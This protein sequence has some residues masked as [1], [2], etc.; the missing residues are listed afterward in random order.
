MSVKN[1]Y[2]FT[3]KKRKEFL[4]MIAG[5]M[6]RGV[7]AKALGISRW[8]VTNHMKED[9]AFAEA[10]GE[11]EKDADEL[12]EDALYAAACSGNVVAIQVWLYNRQPDVW[13]DK[14]KVNTEIT[15]KDG[16]ELVIK[17]IEV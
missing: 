11:A 13:A 3:A 14:R 8:T 10:V 6:R 16:G 7:A 2:K 17:I 1:P 5:G 9:E 15:G 12:V 4:G